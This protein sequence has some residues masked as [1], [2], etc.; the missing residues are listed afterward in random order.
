V[1]IAREV[2][3]IDEGFEAGCLNSFQKLAA[4]PFF[5]LAGIRD[6]SVEVELIIVGHGQ[7]KFPSDQAKVPLIGSV[8]FYRIHAQ[9]AHVCA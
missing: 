9:A 6:E 4:Y 5:V 3:E 2:A 8:G 1:A 7:G